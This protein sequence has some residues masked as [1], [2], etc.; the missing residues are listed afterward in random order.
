M[1]NMIRRIIGALCVIWVCGC[2]SLD[3]VQGSRISEDKIA[4]FIK[5]KTTKEEVVTALG[6]PQD[7]KLEGGKQILIYKY[8]RIS[9]LSNEGSDTMFIFNAD[10][11]LEDIMRSQGS[12]LPN[13]LT[14]K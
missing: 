10:G 11:I 9:A 3:Y 8:Q 4:S 13:P 5:G 2:S 14:G 1:N 12:S 7:L 6:G